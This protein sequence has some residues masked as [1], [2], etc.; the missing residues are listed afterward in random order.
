M[1]PTPETHRYLGMWRPPWE[2]AQMEAKNKR[3]PQ[4]R[5]GEYLQ[6]MSINGTGT[7]MSHYLSGHFDTP[8]YEPIRSLG[9]S[10]TMH[11][12]PMAAQP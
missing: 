3:E 1:T 2:D 11:D 4:C 6:M 9:Q 8:Q 5:C 12:P 10:T 7:L